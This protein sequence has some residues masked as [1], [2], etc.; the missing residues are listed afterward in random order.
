MITSDRRAYRAKMKKNR[1]IRIQKYKGRK[2]GVNI[3][4]AID[5]LYEL[6][7][8]QELSSIEIARYTGIPVSTITSITRKALGKIAP[9][10]GGW[11]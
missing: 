10:M 3:D 2:Q 11:L 7:A 4:M 8:G 1:D 9:V 6:T 5:N